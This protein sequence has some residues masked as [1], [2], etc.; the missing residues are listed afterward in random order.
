MNWNEA[1][2]FSLDTW[3]TPRVADFLRLLGGL[4]GTAA[5]GALIAYCGYLGLMADDA[6]LKAGKSPHSGF[7][8]EYPEF[9]FNRDR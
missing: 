5:I 7:C 3:F 9:E 4:L 1:P 8:P 2:L 6:E